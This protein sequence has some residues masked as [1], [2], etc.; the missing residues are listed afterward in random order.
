MQKTQVLYRAGDSCLHRLDARIK[1]VLGG[2]LV[3]CLFSSFNPQRLGLIAALWCLCAVLSRQP[4]LHLW[5]VLRLLKWL[6]L[7]SLLLHLF[8]TP[9][10][11]LFGLRW[12][13][14]D[15]L[16]N[17]LCVDV[18]IVLAVL[19]S[20]L[21]STTTKSECLAS[22][23]ASVLSPLRILKV[24]VKEIG[25][26]FTLV[27]HFFPLIK[28]EVLALKS[29]KGNAGQPLLIRLKNWAGQLELILLKLLEQGD[30]LAHGIVEESMRGGD[31]EREY[32]PPPFGGLSL[33]ILLA[34]LGV[35]FLI[36]QI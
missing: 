36:W 32:T 12:L 24:P 16:I 27:L 28:T 23:L 11:T 13:S 30:R 9:G 5:R 2:A 10:R 25:A 14:L 17:G 7:F 31:V 22:G 26:M 3:V 8:F 1:L 21:I 15:G 6:L 29:V 4:L 19:I 35:V 20:L 34:G 18:Q 33:F